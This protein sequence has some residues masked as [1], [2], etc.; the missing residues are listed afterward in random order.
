MILSASPVS[1]KMPTRPA[2]LLPDERAPDREFLCALTISRM[3]VLLS[4]PSVRS[5]ASL[6]PGW[7]RFDSGRNC[8]RPDRSTLAGTAALLGDSISGVPQA[9][10]RIDIKTVQTITRMKPEYAKITNRARPGVKN[11]QGR[12]PLACG[13]V[14]DCVTYLTG[15]AEDKP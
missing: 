4:T 5:I 3:R 8:Q 9:G 10:N 14:R 12:Q 7:P 2:L 1:K 6:M 11:C 13:L 15:T